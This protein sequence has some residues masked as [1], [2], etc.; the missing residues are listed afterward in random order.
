MRI[1]YQKVVEKIEGLE[2]SQKELTAK[3]AT[4]RAQ[5]NQVENKTN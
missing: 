2:V 5:V 4:V 1:N 3:I